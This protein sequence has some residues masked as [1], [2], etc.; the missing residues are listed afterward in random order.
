M[1]IIILVGGDV[2]DTINISDGF[3]VRVVISVTSVRRSGVSIV[4][5]IYWG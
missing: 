2:I 3:S 1:S 5:N 4:S